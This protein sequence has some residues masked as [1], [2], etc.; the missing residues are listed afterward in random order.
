MQLQQIRERVGGRIEPAEL[1]E[2]WPEDRRVVYGIDVDRSESLADGAM[3][4]RL[5]TQK[6]TKAGKWGECRRFALS[7]EQWVH[8]TDAE[9][10]AIARAIVGADK[11]FFLP[12]GEPMLD[13][14]P[15]TIDA[16]LRRIVETGRCHVVL[17]GEISPE[18]VKWDDLEAWRFTLSVRP[19]ENANGHHIVAA[20]MRDGETVPLADVSIATPSGW[21][22]VGNRV[23][24]LDTAGAWPLLAEMRGHD[25]LIVP[26]AES[27][28]LVS[29][30]LALPSIPYLQLPPSLGIETVDGNPKPELR[31][32]PRR[33]D[34]PGVG[35]LA[36]EVWFD[37]AGHHVS[38]HDARAVVFDASGKRLIRR[39]RTSESKRLDELMRQEVRL[40][41]DGTGVTVSI[42]SDRLPGVVLELNR[43]GWRVEA[44]GTLYRAAGA[45]SV[46]VKSGIDWFDMNLDLSFDGV[47]ARTPELLKALRSGQRM[48][49]LDDGT[50]GVLPD[51]WLAR[52]AA[53]LELGEASEEGA[54]RFA[55]SQTAVLDA[56]LRT[57]PEARVDEVF[58]NARKQLRSFQGVEAIDPGTDF[59]GT[60]RD[61]QREGLGWLEFLRKFNFGGCLADDMGLGKTI[62]V[63]ALLDQRRTRP[64]DGS[65]RTSLVVV[66]RSLVFN[67]V[68]EAKKFTPKLR[69]LDH[70]GIDRARSPE[71]FAKY[72]LIITTYGTLRRDVGMLREIEFD[73][74]V[75]DESQAVKNSSTASAKSVRLL[76]GRHRL[77]MS[78]TPVENHLGELWSL[79]DFL[80]PGMLG[81]SGVFK[82]IGNGNGNSNSNGHPNSHSNATA[83]A[84]SNPTAP[85]SAVDSD[86][87]PDEKSDPDGS[88]IDGR[89]LIA[90]AV[91]PFILRRTKSQVARELPPRV[92]QTIFCQLEDE[93]RRRYDEL[94]EHYRVALLGRD[95]DG[96]STMQV[97]E[98]LLRL[99]QAACHP[100]LLDASRAAESSAKFDTLL[101]QLEEIQ[102]GGGKALVFSQ[103]TS[104]LALLRP[105]LDERR[106]NYEYL[107]GQTRDR[108]VCVERFQ[109]DPD[110]TLFLISLKAGG[111]G[112]NLTAAEYVF[113]LD[114]W[115][116]PAVEAQAIDRAHR[117]G[118]TR[119]V[120]AY[121][122]I[123]SDTIEEKVLQLQAGKR[124]LADAII[125]EDNSLIRNLTTD[126]LKLL[127]S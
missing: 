55:R 87:N 16:V 116:N 19:D 88:N 5:Y 45:F 26:A 126:D 92:E 77:A 112:L 125:N 109:N 63:L 30:L 83:P 107:D 38:S 74:V 100:G 103:F 69:V 127:L 91:R 17:A 70:S 2:R 115:W 58:D 66:P 81:S 50:I 43:R 14:P 93:Q 75:L 28:K 96:R 94:K 121:R 122:L 73:Y 8:A 118:Q 21:A 22:I 52:Y 27:D 57:L 54:I 15:W 18:P 10:R 110:C 68:A 72:D 80:N 102:Q 36:L 3:A 85:G 7:I 12:S 99:R 51:E 124:D 65:P 6:L 9:D 79:F 82:L 104:L 35:Q 37:Y 120:F 29:E 114:P 64:D 39:D 48:V 61:Y 86:A 97:L 105:R 31:I 32:F 108:Q 90:Q 46:S 41:R 44:R 33:E 113:L 49:V 20:L 25:E 98:A 1:V 56:M 42:T 101:A 62:Q 34:E 95:S 67:W 123:A 60:L 76:R 13:L 24:R 89:Q 47:K 59:K 78:G 117:I 11:D 53:V 84:K 40:D 71:N 106:F 4:I 23:A 111:I 119:T